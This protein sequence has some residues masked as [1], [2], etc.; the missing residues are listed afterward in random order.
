MDVPVLF[1]SFGSHKPCL[2]EDSICVFRENTG[3]TIGFCFYLLLLLS[4]FSFRGIT[5]SFS[6]S[7]FKRKTHW[8]PGNLTL[9]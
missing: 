7:L 3:L 9:Y 2:D 1:L 4:T 6:F 8:N 5:P